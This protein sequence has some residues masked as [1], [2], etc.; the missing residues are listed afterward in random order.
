MSGL[1]RNEIIPF[2]YTL[3]GA[4]MFKQSLCSFTVQPTE[5]T[6]FTITIN[7]LELDFFYYSDLLCF[8]YHD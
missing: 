2:K 8:E 6:M 7:K 3:I 4:T 1:N 5:N